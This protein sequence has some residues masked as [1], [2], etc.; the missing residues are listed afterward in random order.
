MEA[1]S[2]QRFERCSILRNVSPIA[3]SHDCEVGFAVYK[4]LRQRWIGRFGKRNVVTVGVGHHH[5]LYLTV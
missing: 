1:I 3:G 4:L 2:S 5:R